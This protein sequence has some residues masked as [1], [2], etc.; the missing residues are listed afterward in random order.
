MHQKARKA[1]SEFL[2]GAFS[3]SEL[4]RFLD[5]LCQRH[6]R[7]GTHYLQ[8]NANRIDSAYAAT[9]L[10]VNRGLVDDRFFAKLKEVRPTRAEE[11]LE[12]KQLCETFPTASAH[13]VGR[14]WGTVRREATRMKEWGIW[15][16]TK[17]H[18]L[19]LRFVDPRDRTRFPGGVRFPA[20]VDVSTLA[21]VVERTTR[22]IAICGAAGSGK[23]GVLA[24]LALHLADRQVGLAP[25]IARALN[26]SFVAGERTLDSYVRE[27]AFPGPGDVPR[28]LEQLLLFDGL[29]EVA[30][31]N[32][33]EE[34]E[35]RRRDEILRTWTWDA[36]QNPRVAAIHALL[37]RESKVV[38]T[39]RT[40][41]LEQLRSHLG[42]DGVIVLEVLPLSIDAIRA[43]VD[44]VREL[45]DGW[46]ALLS[47]PQLL[48]MFMVAFGATADEL[49]RQRMSRSTILRRIMDRKFDAW[50]AAGSRASLPAEVARTLEEAALRAWRLPWAPRIDVLS[51]IQPSLD[52]EHLEIALAW[53]L[54]KWTQHGL[55]FQHPMLRDLFAVRSLASDLLRAQSP[56][57]DYAAWA[58]GE[59][60]PI[61]GEAVDQLMQGLVDPDKFCRGSSAW[62][63]GR[64]GLGDSRVREA[65]RR[66]LADDFP[67]ARGWAAWALGEVG[68]LEDVTAIR[69]VAE[70]PSS[71]RGMTTIPF[72][73]VGEVAQAAISRLHAK[74]EV[75]VARGSD[76]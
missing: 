50:R 14:Y 51:G 58:L 69:R 62:A 76:D 66:T 39:C 63:L 24:D 5:F 4:R 42:L 25:I 19:E 28:V 10:L 56:R 8:S 54:L 73:T 48:S 70:D 27:Y 40:R 74:K 34:S 44:P 35:T 13:I 75:W 71:V 7:L 45:D 57:T 22:S 6:D 41:A 65:L 2:L 37:A 20:K 49:P 53:D 26:W 3:P 64:I 72:D 1:V 12:L 31:S 68:E 52:E 67:G 61:A 47:N 30:L 55:E 32:Q 15:A 46:R 16:T 59:M 38:F 33:T 43:T 18:S 36:A 11:I 17:R 23:T 21:D 60:G 9:E 29:D